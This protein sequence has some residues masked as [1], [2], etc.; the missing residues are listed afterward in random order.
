MQVWIDAEQT[1]ESVE[2][3]EELLKMGIDSFCTDF[4]LKVTEV[5]D[6]YIEQTSALSTH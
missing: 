2:I 4:P 5:R 6:L 3:Y 1:I